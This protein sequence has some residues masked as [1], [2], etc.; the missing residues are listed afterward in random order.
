[1]WVPKVQYVKQGAVVTLTF[2]FFQKAWIPS[3]KGVGGS[4]TSS[5]GA[6]ESY[7]VRRDSLIAVGLRFGE[8]L[9]P[10][11]EA[12]LASVQDL[13]ISFNF[14]FDQTVE[15]SKYLCYLEKPGLEDEIK[16]TRSQYHGYYELDVVLRSAVPAIRFDVRMYC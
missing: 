8:P 3:N 14:W 11:V 13:G 16:P 6:V 12:W 15:T 5:S 4:G 10:Q 1:M 9:W 7:V 2:A